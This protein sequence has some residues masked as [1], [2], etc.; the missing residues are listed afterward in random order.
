MSAIGM[1]VATV[2]CVAAWLDFRRQDSDIQYFASALVGIFAAQFVL[3][4]AGI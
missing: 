4:L 2:I 3:R 1:G